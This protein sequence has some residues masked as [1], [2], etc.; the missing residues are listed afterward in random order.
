MTPKWSKISH[1]FG[2]TIMV[3]G[4]I[5]SLLRHRN[6]VWRFIRLSVIRLSVIRLSVIRLSVIRLDSPLLDSFASL[7]SGGYMR[8]QEVDNYLIAILPTYETACKTEK[9]KL[10]D[11][12]Q[13]VTKRSR[14]H[15]YT[16]TPSQSSFFLNY[17]V[18]FTKKNA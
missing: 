15:L 6:A 11:H 9:G 1:N 4:L 3:L 16:F 14:K 13:L 12:A 7:G 10:L 8:H 17:R 2:I 18:I 5:D